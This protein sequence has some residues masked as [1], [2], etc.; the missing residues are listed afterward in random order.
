MVGMNPHVLF[1]GWQ[2]TGKIDGGWVDAENIGGEKRGNLQENNPA[3]THIPSWFWP[4]YFLQD[5]NDEKYTLYILKRS[6]CH[7]LYLAYLSFGE[8]L[9]LVDGKGIFWVTTEKLL[10]ISRMIQWIY[11][12]LLKL[13]TAIDM[14]SSEGIKVWRGRERRGRP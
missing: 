10:S 3:Y 2:A 1:L 13:Q 9:K 12:I 8:S 5:D 6:S 4:S 7:R 11:Y 14:T